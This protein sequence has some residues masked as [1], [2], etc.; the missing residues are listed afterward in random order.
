M[1]INYTTTS[2]HIHA[3]TRNIYHYSTVPLSCQ[4]TVAQLYG[5]ML[6]NIICYHPAYN[7]LE[8][9]YLSALK[10]QF[11]H[12]RKNKTYFLTYPHCWGCHFLLEN[13]NCNDQFD[14]KMYSL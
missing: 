13:P 1:W 14:L 5:A 12:I 2:H 8:I 3:H 9:I 10:G 7:I 4:S 11:N 6:A